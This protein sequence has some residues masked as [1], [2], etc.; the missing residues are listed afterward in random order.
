MTKHPI[1]IEPTPL[2]DVGLIAL[3]WTPHEDDVLLVLT[4]HFGRFRAI[5]RSHTDSSQIR[6]RLAFSCA[7]YLQTEAQQ[8]HFGFWPCR[9]SHACDIVTG[10]LHTLIW[11][12]TTNGSICTILR[13]SLIDPY[14]PSKPRLIP[15]DNKTFRKIRE[16]M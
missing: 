4:S 3:S 2:L 8:G 14:K 9:I 15:I 11:G 1:S 5:Q 6:G 10:K 13:P 7:A 12:I 16:S